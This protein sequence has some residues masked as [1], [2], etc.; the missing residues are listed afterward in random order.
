M[1][2]YNFDFTDVGKASGE[3]FLVTL[4]QKTPFFIIMLEHRKQHFPETVSLLYCDSVLV[5]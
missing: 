5:V 2:P 3:N 4:L 1:P